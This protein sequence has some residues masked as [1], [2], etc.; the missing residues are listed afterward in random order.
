MLFFKNNNT[1]NHNILGVKNCI[2]TVLLK[3]VKALN[4]QVL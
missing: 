1:F 4:L 3:L 2:A